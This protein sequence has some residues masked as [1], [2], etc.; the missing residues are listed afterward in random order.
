VALSELTT[1][2]LTSV[3]CDGSPR[4]GVRQRHH[5]KSGRQCVS[6]FSHF[7]LGAR[8]DDRALSRTECIVSNAK[9]LCL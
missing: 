2:S 6:V 3:N 1:I 9:T 4:V 5:L 8:I 7:P